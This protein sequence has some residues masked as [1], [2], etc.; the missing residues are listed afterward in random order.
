LEVPSRMDEVSHLIE[1]DV[2]E[3]EKLDYGRLV[4]KSKTVFTGN[5]HKGHFAG[6]GRYVWLDGTIYQ[7]TLS[8]FFLI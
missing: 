5:I 3:E 4:F 8:D 2:A 7:V 1:A 6:P